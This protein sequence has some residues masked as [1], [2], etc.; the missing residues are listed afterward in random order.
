ML[1]SHVCRSF[2]TSLCS[3]CTFL[4][5]SENISNDVHLLINACTSEETCHRCDAATSWSN[6]SSL[7]IISQS[8]HACRSSMKAAS[9]V[10]GTP[11]SFETI[12]EQIF[13]LVCTILVLLRKQLSGV[14]QMCSKK[15]THVS[16]FMNATSAVSTEYLLLRMDPRPPCPHMIQEVPN[17][18]RTSFKHGCFHTY[19]Y[20]YIYGI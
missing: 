5:A 6:R 3:L 2:K 17:R 13:F 18:G 19:S 8:P 1:K 9:L 16:S 15:Q 10:S 7:V 14:L 4:A 20:S 12:H 11:G